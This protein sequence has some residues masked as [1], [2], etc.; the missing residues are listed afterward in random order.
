MSCKNCKAQKKA[1][2]LN[3]QIQSNIS[4]FSNDLDAQKEELIE[5]MFSGGASILSPW[6]KII[7]IFVAWIPLAVGYYHIIKFFISIL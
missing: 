5:K 1:K 6:Q 4:S 3:N 2:K 7:M